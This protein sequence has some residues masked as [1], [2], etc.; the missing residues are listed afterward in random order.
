VTLQTTELLSAGS[1]K[2]SGLLNPQ[3]LSHALLGGFTS[4]SAFRNSRLRFLRRIFCLRS[5]PNLDL[6]PLRSDKL[7]ILVLLA[8]RLGLALKPEILGG[9]VAVQLVWPG[10]RSAL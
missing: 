2:H 4:P 8:L 9:I 6:S 5:L 3:L 7:D 10:G 1:A